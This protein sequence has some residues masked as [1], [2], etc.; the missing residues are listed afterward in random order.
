VTEYPHGPAAR[1]NWYDAAAYCNWL[2]EREGIPEEQWC[3]VPNEDG[4][5]AEGMRIPKDVFQR[6]GYRFPD[7]E[8]WRVAV[9]AGLQDSWFFGDDVRLAKDYSWSVFNSNRSARRVGSLRPSDWGLFD[10]GGNVSEWTLTDPRRRIG[11]GRSDVLIHERRRLLV[12]GGTYLLN[13][14]FQRWSAAQIR[15]PSSD[16]HAVG[17]RLARTLRE[18]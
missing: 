3:F 5:Y 4:E 1:V 11:I 16:F 10:A 13:E 2:S 8:E 15:V 9:R 6:T 18:D 17:V 7:I 12:V 14:M